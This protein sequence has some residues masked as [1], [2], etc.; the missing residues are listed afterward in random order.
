MKLTD[1]LKNSL[2]S[3]SIICANDG[4][5][6]LFFQKGH[7]FHV[8][9]MDFLNFFSKSPSIICVIDGFFKH[10]FKKSINYMCHWLT[11]KTFFKKSINFMFHY[12]LLKKSINLCLKSPSICGLKCHLQIVTQIDGLSTSKK[13]INLCDILT[14]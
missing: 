7:Q 4:L 5:F 14:W 11:F 6:K 3:P 13:S 8:S 2:K 9:F 1:F 10:Y 12:F